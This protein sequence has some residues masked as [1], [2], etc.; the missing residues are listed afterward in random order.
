MKKVKQKAYE[1]FE[2]NF[3]ANIEIGTINGLKQIHSFLFGGLYDFAGQIRHKNI[4][5]K[6]FQ[7]A[8]A[9][10]L[11][12]TLNSIEKM[13]ENTIGEIIKKYIEMNIAH[14]FLEGNGRATRI[15][16]DL[17]LKKNLSVCVDWSKIEKKEYLEAMEISPTNE[18]KILNLIKKALTHEINNREIIIKRI[19]YSY[20]YEEID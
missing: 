13:P 16:L 7:F 5:K 2:S 3:I 6:G 18:N 20:Y 15:W 4:A 10:Y 12:E 8:N 11:K 19:D 1:L 17:I 14:P 9:L